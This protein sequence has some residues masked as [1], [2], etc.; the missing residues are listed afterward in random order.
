VGPNAGSECPSKD[1]RNLTLSGTH[2]I[3]PCEVEEVFYEHPKVFEVAVVSKLQSTARDD[4]NATAIPSTPVAPASP[5]ITAYVV[6]RHR[7]HVTAEELLAYARERLEAYQMP[8]RIVF[9]SE[10]PKNA[11]G[12]VVKGLF[13]GKEPS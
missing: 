5:L 8:Q 9:L 4:G 7:Q 1:V 3:Y 10:L 11:D 6:V 12:K 2:Q 13:L